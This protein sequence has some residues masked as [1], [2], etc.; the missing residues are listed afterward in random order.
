MVL[1]TCAVHGHGEGKEQL[2]EPDDAR[3]VRV[4]DPDNVFVNQLKI[5]PEIG[6]HVR[7][8]NFC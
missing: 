8:E 2:V 4:E 1:R 6:L 5:V 3:V 7:A